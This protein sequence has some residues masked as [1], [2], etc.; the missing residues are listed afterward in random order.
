MSEATARKARTGKTRNA[1]LEAAE[2]LFAERGFEATRLEDIAARVGIRRASIV[3]YFRDKRELYGAVIESVLL[4]LRDAIERAIAGDLPPAD[5]IEAAITAWVDYVG[6]RPTTAQF[7]LRESADANAE[8][9]FLQRAQPV[10]ELIR[11]EFL[12][13]PE[14]REA[15][16][17][18]IDPI[19]L[20]SLITGSTVFFVSA[21]PALLPHYELQPTRRD[22]LEA[23][24][25]ELLGVVR[26]LLGTRG[27]RRS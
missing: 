1:I 22:Q 24:K 20:A 13:N 26:R 15:G 5:R 27:P 9:G 3:Y 17:A 11:R 10:A 19:H 16:F 14:V 12:F 6:A 23:H 21:V 4:G 8:R 18:D 2:E 25:R 7:I